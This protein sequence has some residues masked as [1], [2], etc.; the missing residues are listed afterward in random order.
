MS[1]QGVCDMNHGKS[2][3][4]VVGGRIRFLRK[5]LKISQ[6]ELGKAVGYTSSGSVS[7]VE[8][9]KIMMEPEKLIKAAEVLKVDPIVLFTREELTQDQI[10]MAVNLF[11][12]FSKKE[13]SPHLD[14]IKALLETASK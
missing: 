14:S 1:L 13:K 9:G 8:R 4:E 10:L 3:A 5:R 12:M 11:K 7:L 6:T 2:F